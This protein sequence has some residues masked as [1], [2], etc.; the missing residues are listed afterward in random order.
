MD[1]RCNVNLFEETC[2]WKER[3]IGYHIWIT[4]RSSSLVSNIE[5]KEVESRLFAV[6]TFQA[7][8]TAA[9]YIGVPCGEKEVSDY[10]ITKN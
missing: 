6:S 2:Y 4:V 9:I 7:G 5:D 8:Q 3:E 1:I 10:E